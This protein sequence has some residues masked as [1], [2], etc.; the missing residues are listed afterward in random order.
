[1]SFLDNIQWVTITSTSPLN[2]KHRHNMNIGY[3]SC[4]NVLVCVVTGS[5]LNCRNILQVC[6]PTFL[7]VLSKVSD[8]WQGLPWIDCFVKSHYLFLLRKTVYTCCIFSKEIQT[9]LLY[10]VTKIASCIPDCYKL[11][12]VKKWRCRFVRSSVRISANHAFQDN[13]CRIFFYVV[14]FV[15]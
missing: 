7:H 12:D 6:F 14:I 11:C 8:T 10:F 15:R 5:R 9:S 2:F 1:L 3:I 13:V 4:L